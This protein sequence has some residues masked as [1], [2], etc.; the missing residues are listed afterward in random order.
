MGSRYIYDRALRGIADPASYLPLDTFLTW[1]SK[2]INNHDQ[3]FEA[4]MA[5]ARRYVKM[6]N[7]ILVK[8]SP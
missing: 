3:I 4:Y 2:L 7:E 8:A 5:T 6:G 1:D